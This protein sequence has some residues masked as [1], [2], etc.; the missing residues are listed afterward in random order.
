MLVT[1]I[2][3]TSNLFLSS[4]Y[5]AN[6][7]TKLF[8]QAPSTGVP[9]ATY[10][11]TIN[12]TLSN[13][14]NGPNGTKSSA[15]ATISININACD[16]KSQNPLSP[17]SVTIQVGGMVNWTN[18]DKLTHEFI[19][20]APNALINLFDSGLV[21]PG[22]TAG[23]MF[24]NPGTFSYFDRVC[25]NLVGT[26]NVVPSSQIQQQAM[27]P[28]PLNS[29]LAR[30]LPP[31]Q[32]NATL[33]RQLIIPP[34]SLPNSTAS[35]QVNTTL[36][37]P[38]AQS[39][40]LQPNATLLAN[41]TGQPSQKPAA[42]TPAPPPQQQ[43]QQQS[44][45]LGFKSRGT[46]NSLIH[47]STAS[48]IASGT[49]IMNVDKGNVTFFDT[50]MTWYKSNG[51]TSHTHEFQ[52][53]KSAGAKMI[54]LPQGANN[55]SFKGIMDVG[56]NHRIVWKNVPTTININ[57]S[58]TISISVADNATNRHFAGQPIFGL[59]TSF[60]SCSDVPGANMEVL[61]ICR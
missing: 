36:P 25:N 45:T 7:F 52:S 31:Q 37:K 24:K 17:K 29:T 33:P 61:P 57:G 40:S 14:S 28:K 5:A 20:G 10:S 43:Q 39:Q 4:G 30:S 34:S 54:S 26:I 51:I 59:V 41:I 15:T 53:F 50:N 56:T 44:Y 3:F 12:Q 2:M 47:T 9:N 38:L 27:T 49:W 19:S 6:A 32:P 16:P 35:S 13:P 58:K 22:K 21:D 1:G 60:I 42:T 23:V 11:P 18:N 48:W 8:P 55:V 46:I